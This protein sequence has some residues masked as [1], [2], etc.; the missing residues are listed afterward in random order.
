ML[1]LRC[2]A[3]LLALAPFSWT[4][5]TV[6]APEPP[7]L[8]IFVVID[9]FRAEYLR[10]FAGSFG[11]S[12]FKRLEKEGMHFIH[13]TYNHFRTTTAPGHTVLMTGAYPASSGIVENYWWDRKSKRRIAVVEDAQEHV[14]G[15]PPGGKKTGSSPLRLLASTIADE[16]KFIDNKKA[17]KVISIS[18]KARAA[19]IMGGRH[20]DGVYWF[21]TPSGSFV[22]SSYYKAI[23][24]EWVVAYNQRRPADVYAGQAWTLSKSK[25]MYAVSNPDSNAAELKIPG[26]SADFPHAY[27]PTSEMPKVYERVE[28]TTAL[29]ALTLEMAREAIAA[30]KLGQGAG[31]DLLLISLSA[32]DLI[33]H[34]YGPNSVEAQEHILG[35]DLLIGEFLS[36][37]EST[38]G[39]QKALVVLTADHGFGALPELATE[40]RYDGRTFN[41]WL[42]HEAKEKTLVEIAE[43]ALDA[44]FGKADWVESFE[45]PALYLHTKASDTA[46]I[47]RQRESVVKDA[48]LASG[49]PLEVFTRSDI[50]AGLLPKTALAQKVQNGFNP[51]RSG[52]VVIVPP[53]H[54]VF[55]PKG[56]RAEYG[57]DH[58]SPYTYD[59]HVPLLFWGAGIAAR[60]VP[61]P[62][63]PNDVAPTLAHILGTAL[64][65]RSEGTPL[66]EL[67]DK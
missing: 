38:L 46:D 1:S 51:E 20:A 27:G 18:G 7:K 63:T 39:K 2:F 48:I 61:R 59:S 17:N 57:T 11:E 45:I 14:V 41:P 34:L 40:Q 58:G 52:D 42:K 12:G 9:G 30:E 26:F 36:H 67:W 28:R 24:P 55:A 13:A 29:D 6:A 19:T 35:L 10:R 62:V 25:A 5:A 43:E 8:T 16:L 33:C 60:V 22:T 66:T 37:V 50:M 21:D 56:D 65:N 49:L 3:V 64:P 44:R 54:W 53:P 4:F 47:R 31:R 32:N 23:L 15:L